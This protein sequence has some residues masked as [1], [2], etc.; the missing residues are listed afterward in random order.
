MSLFELNARMAVKL[1]QSFES[2][3]E[4]DYMEYSFYKEIV[5]KE[6]EGSEQPTDVPQEPKFNVNLPDNLKLK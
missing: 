4:L 1:G 6:M 3:Y 5:K 2:L